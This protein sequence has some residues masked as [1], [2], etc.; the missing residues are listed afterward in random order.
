MENPIKMDDMGGK[1]TIFGNIHIQI[2]KIYQNERRY[3]AVRIRQS[4]FAAR[5]PFGD[6]LGRYKIVVPK[7]PGW[8]KNTNVTK[9]K[10]VVLVFLSKVRF[11]GFEQ[12]KV[13]G[14]FCVFFQDLF[15]VK[16]EFRIYNP[17]SF[18]RSSHLFVFLEVSSI[19]TTIL[20]QTLL[21][22]TLLQHC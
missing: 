2:T 8:W 15:L 1:P 22:N 18:W 21:Y 13:F 11:H 7:V 20:S 4:G 16:V 14:V 19:E 12:Q 17:N 10:W 3:Q 6:F 5:I 9:E